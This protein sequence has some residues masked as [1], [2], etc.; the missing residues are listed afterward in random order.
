MAKVKTQAKFVIDASIKAG[1]VPK[2]RCASKQNLCP[3]ALLNVCDLIT[4]NFMQNS[5]R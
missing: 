1:Y 5:V 4:P 3:K 2:V